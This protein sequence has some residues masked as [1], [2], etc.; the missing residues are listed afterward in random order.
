MTRFI[1]I[2]SASIREIRGRPYAP[3]VASK[4]VIFRNSRKSE[5]CNRLQ[6]NYFQLTL[7]VIYDFPPRG[8]LFFQSSIPRS[9]FRPRVLWKKLLAS[10]PVICMIAL[11]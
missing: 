3:F 5:K 1:Q 9:G 4:I 11:G 6:I 7:I 10:I 8:F 2:E